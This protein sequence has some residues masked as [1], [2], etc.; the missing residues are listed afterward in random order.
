MSGR[1]W[2]TDWA[3]SEFSV[4]S[5]AFLKATSSCLMAFL[6]RRPVVVCGGFLFP[7]R[8]RQRGAATPRS[9]LSGRKETAW[10]VDTRH[11]GEGVTCGRQP[12]AEVSVRPGLPRLVSRGHPSWFGLNPRCDPMAAR[13]RRSPRDFSRSRLFPRGRFRAQTALQSC[14]S[15]SHRHALLGWIDGPGLCR[16]SGKA[17]YLVRS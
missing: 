1:G 5:N 3:R 4:P 8:F 12:S 6:P 16:A 7:L 15:Q 10:L 9:V 17:Y 14:R 11:P 13:L 2:L